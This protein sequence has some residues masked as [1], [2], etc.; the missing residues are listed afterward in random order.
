[1]A[2]SRT[3]SFSLDGVTF[4]GCSIGAFH[5]ADEAQY[6]QAQTKFCILKWGGYIQRFHITAP[7]SYDL[8]RYA[9]E[10]EIPVLVVR[11][12]DDCELRGML[13]LA[14]NTWNI[15]ESG[16]KVRCSVMV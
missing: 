12:Q 4:E 7:H 8:Q 9:L 16:C 14:F 3:F 6:D 1:M 13:H 11:R 15:T 5:L 2:G 10:V